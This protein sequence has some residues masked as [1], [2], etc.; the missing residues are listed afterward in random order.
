MTHD[1]PPV[2]VT[3]TVSGD[4]FGTVVQ[5]SAVGT[6]EINHHHV[7]RR[8]VVEDFRA[9]G[10]PDTR[11]LMAQPSRL[12]DARSQVVPFQHR[13]AELRLLTDW[14]DATDAG[15]SVLLLHG[16][17]GQG[18]T[19]LATELAARSQPWSV[20]QA[21][22]GTAAPPRQDA[23]GD[24]VLL[25]VDYADRWAHG[26]LLG[27]FSDLLVTPQ[28]V[29][30]LLVGRSVRWF[31]ALRGE[32]AEHRVPTT[33]LALPHLAADRRSV[34][35]AAR[36]RYSAPD[37]YDL[38]E[39]DDIEPPASLEDPDFGLVLSLHTAA[40]VAVDARSRGQVPPSSPH[41]LSAYL[42]DREYMAWQRLHDAGRQGSD[43]R[44]PPAVMA[45][46][47]FTAAL[48]GPVSHQSGERTL[49]GLDLP[50]HPQ[51]LL[52]DHRLC[53]PPADRATVLEPL[54]PDR[55]AE[56]F[57]ALLTPGHDVTAYDPDPWT[58]SGTAEILTRESGE[59]PQW[60]S[61]S[62]TFLAA[63]AQRWPHLGPA[64]LFP[65]LLED[66]RLALDAGSAALTALV[67]VAGV[68]EVLEA[69]ETVFPEDRDFN[70]DLGI[71]VVSERLTEHR[72]S[73]YSEDPLTRAVLH[74]RL[75]GRYANAG[76]HDAAVATAETA[77]AFWR[78]QGDEEGLAGSLTNLGPWL[79]AV[80][81]W[82]DWLPVVREAVAMWRHL[83]EDCRGGNRD[84]LAVA[85]ANLGSALWFSGSTGEALA[86]V[87]EAVE[88]TRLL[89]EDEP[90][91]HLPGLA[92]ALHNLG[93]YLA[94][95]GRW[96]EGVAAAEEAVAIRRRL[97]LAD[98]PA[99]LPGL[100]A[101]LLSFAP[102]LGDVGRQ[103]EAL[104]LAEEGADIW[105]QL[106]KANP[107]A[108]QPGLAAALNNLGAVL[109]ASHRPAEALPVAHESVALRRV[110]ADR[111][112]AVHLPDLAR[113]LTNLSARLS[114]L[115]RWEEALPAAE[116][117]LQI[118]RRLA[119]ANPAVY[120]HDLAIALTNLGRVHW[121]TDRLGEAIEEAEEA[122]GIW[123]RLS[124]ENP[125]AHLGDLAA[126]LA[127]LGTWAAD[128][129]QPEK[130]V[131]ALTEAKAYYQR[132]TGPQARPFD[133]AHCTSRLSEVL[134][135]QLRWGEGAEVTAEAVALRREL[136]EHDPATHLPLLAGSLAN[137]RGVLR[138]LDQDE[139]ALG[140]AQ[141]LVAVLRDLGHLPG[142]AEALGELA[143][144]Q[145]G[146]GR[147]AEALATAEMASEVLGKLVTQGGTEH[148][149]EFAHFQ[150]VLSEG[151]ARTGRPE[152]AL[153]RA[154]VASGILR[155]LA[156]DDDTHLPALAQALTS[157]GHRAAVLGR[158]DLAVTATAEAADVRQR[159]GETGVGLA[160]DLLNLGHGLA[161]LGRHDEAVHPAEQ[162]VAAWRRLAHDDPR[163]LPVLDRA[164]DMLAR[165]VT[166]PG[167]VTDAQEP[168][169]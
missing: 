61:R 108:H 85:L 27:L 64:S 137:L 167:P 99:H 34:F 94:A 41:E 162:A 40:L 98:P 12:L 7:I 22:L 52:L 74:D 140:V 78:R 147:T 166:G 132:L 38:S 111:D 89:A 130:A 117:A 106:A 133:L 153:T 136:A 26:E 47:V 69:V 63:A 18:K 48:T 71:A 118:R 141:D 143:D 58:T 116:E 155:L 160:G 4:V 157:L 104:R 56:D 29:R 1:L 168:P 23:D 139:Q 119:L 115:R 13:E 114:D 31:A 62:V 9:P 15:L 138:E 28:R 37:L 146:L 105:R 124:E 158:L 14:R 95:L 120:L 110:L 5:A 65:L 25:I 86:A 144:L 2:G 97:A 169:V 59:A 66:P 44:T 91:D 122:T 125:A 156:R 75:A 82:E 53:Y 113:S 126:G 72:L 96:E 107:E 128:A 46:T 36:D 10:P 55:L 45:R 16:P 33:D 121:Q 87:V 101:A 77:V 6:V 154:N 73:T 135:E 84:G 80:G 102:R 39:V 131:A 148:L 83:G 145:Q 129:G 109:A 11:W 8:H 20:R 163:H 3:N 76:M 90:D 88:L 81:R 134:L 112:P 68:L 17:G 67:E 51:R 43:Y 123:R 152:E 54:Y 60:T 159:L 50:E 127:N 19:R 79:G 165:L 149:P 150:V 100:A 103:E 32:L 57:L 161:V 151:L 92:A 35:T 21:V 42:L 24:G 49:A 93:A 164:L 30:V 70:L 142:F